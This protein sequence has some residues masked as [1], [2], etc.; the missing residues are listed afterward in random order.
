MKYKLNI[1]LYGLLSAAYLATGI[2]GALVFIYLIP[3]LDYF[4]LYPVIPVF[5]WLTGMIL[6]NALDRCRSWN[7][8]QLTNVYMM[9][10][11]IKFLFTIIFLLVCIHF[12]GDDRKSFAISIMFNYLLY[13]GL[14]LYIFYLY[15]KREKKY[16]SKK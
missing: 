10:R 1:R 15:N 16:D 6:N 2:I 5:Y 9:C 13:T 14:E 7:P 11:M 8:G 4:E 12:V 3:I